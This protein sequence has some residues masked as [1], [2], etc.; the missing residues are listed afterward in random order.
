M[1]KPRAAEAATVSPL[2]G[3]FDEM[4]DAVLGVATA[5]KDPK[6]RAKVDT[7]EVPLHEIYNNSDVRL[8]ASHYDKNTASALKELRGSKCKLKLLSD[9]ADVRLPGQFVR[10]WAQDKEHGLPYVNAS[11]L[12]GLMGIGQAGDSTRYLSKQ[13]ETNLEELVI[14]ECFTFPRG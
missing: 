3:K 1:K 11:D 9:L 2:H 13:T 6:T 14:R 12:M 7:W 5:Q 4:I 8:D 10:I